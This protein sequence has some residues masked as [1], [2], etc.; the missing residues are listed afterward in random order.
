MS[1]LTNLEKKI[2]F[3]LDRKTIISMVRKN[4]AYNPRIT[5]VRRIQRQF[6]PHISEGTIY[7]ILKKISLVVAREYRVYAGRP[8]YIKRFKI[9]ISKSSNTAGYF[10]KK[11]KKSTIVEFTPKQTPRRKS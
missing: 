6:L 1:D 8:S 7:S 2:F 4:L 11:Y 3:S 10:R 9:T 5:L